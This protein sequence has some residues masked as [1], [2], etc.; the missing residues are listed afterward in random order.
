MRAEYH[1]KHLDE[2]M[3]K[4]NRIANVQVVFVD[5]EKYSQRRTPVQIEVVDQLT[6]ALREAHAA[7]SKDYIE[8]AQANNLN[9]QEDII[10]I[11]TGDGAAIVFTFDGLHDI[12]LKFAKHLLKTSDS[13]SITSPCAK[14]KAEA[15][16][17]CHSYFNLRVGIS[18]G[19]AII[20]KDVNG[21]YNVAGG[22]MNM[23]SRVM[24]LAERN[25]IMFTADAHKQ[26]VDMV[27]DS[28][29]AS[30]FVE[31][32]YVN[33]KH[34][35]HINIYQFTDSDLDFLNSDPPAELVLVQRAKV[36]MKKITTGMPFEGVDPDDMDKER[37]T[38]QM[39]Q[40][41]NMM[42]EFA[43]IGKQLPPR[44]R[45]IR[46]EVRSLPKPKKRKK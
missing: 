18:E 41:A 42:G 2:I 23:A 38:K 4:H 28:K 12:H 40:I 33:I 24:G 36:A 29:L 19:K 44:T 35:V 13:R 9:F 46:S 16:C 22:V 25:Q 8:Y 30:H 43:R 26:I 14:F 5:I 32:K 15:W 45:T 34:G 20:Y 7:I 3:E 6:A 37:V 39:E 10:L 27:D 1:S 21:G 31:Y 17:N 11:P